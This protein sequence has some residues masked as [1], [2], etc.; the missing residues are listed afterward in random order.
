MILYV[1][2]V[3]GIVVIDMVYLD[4]DNMEGFEVEVCLI[5]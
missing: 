5:K 1:V 4:V 2:W 3:V